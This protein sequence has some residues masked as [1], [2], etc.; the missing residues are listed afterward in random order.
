MQ[1]FA[2]TEIYQTV[3]IHVVQNDTLRLLP[4]S[5]IHSKE[6]YTNFCYREIRRRFRFCLGCEAREFYE[7]WEI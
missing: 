2:R 7:S 5:S 4:K 3:N 1:I 6:I